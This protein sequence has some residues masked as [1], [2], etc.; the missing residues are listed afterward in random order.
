MK[1]I[2]LIFIIAVIT[3]FAVTCPEEIID[4]TTW[5][6][7]ES[8]SEVLLDCATG[9]DGEQSRFC[10][11]NGHWETIISNCTQIIC[12]SDM[13]EYEYVWP[14]T[15]AYTQN[16]QDCKTGYMGEVK[17][18]CNETGFW[19]PTEVDC[20][21]AC[22]NEILG[23]IEWPMTKEK[24]TVTN[25]CGEGTIGGPLT[26]NCEEGGIWGT[27]SDIDDEQREWPS[28]SIDSETTL[29]CNADEF[30]VYTRYCNH[31]GTWGLIVSTCKPAI[32]ESVT[33]ENQLIWP[34]TPINQDATLTCG[35]EM[36]GSISRS[37]LADG[38]WST[39]INTCVPTVCQPETDDQEHTWPKTPINEI[40]TLTCPT[41][42]IGSIT[43]QCKDNGEWDIINNSCTLAIC[44]S[45]TDENQ[46][47]WP[48]TPIN[49]DATLSCGEEMT[50]SIIRSCLSNAT[51]ST[52]I[53]TCVPTVC[54]PETDDQGRTWPKTPINTPYILECGEDQIGSIS[55]ICK[56]NGEWGVIES[57]CRPSVCPKNT[58]NEIEWPKTSIETTSTLPC[59][60]GYSG[61][62]S[63]YCKT[64]GEWDIPNINTC[65]RNVCYDDQHQGLTWPATDSL[66]IASITCPETYTGVTTRQCTASGV[67]E[68]A[69]MSGCI[70]NKCPE[71]TTI[72]LWE[73][74]EADQ[75][76]TKTCVVG[77]GSMNRYC[78]KGGIW[79]DIESHCEL[80]SCSSV[81]DEDGNIWPDTPVY[82]VAHVNCPIGYEGILNR[83]CN[84]EGQTQYWEPIQ[85]GCTII[86]CNSIEEDGYLWPQTNYA[87]EASVPCIAGYTGSLTRICLSTGNFSDITNNCERITCSP[88]TDNYGTWNITNSGEYATQQC[89]EYYH[90]QYKRLCSLEG[91]WK[92][93]I[94]ECE[95][96]KCPEETYNGVLYPSIPVMTNI[97]T[98][99]RLGYTGITERICNDDMTWEEPELDCVRNVCPFTCDGILCFSETYESEVV[100]IPCT[101]GSGGV[102]KRTCNVD[103][104]WGDIID[105]CT[106]LPCT[107]PVDMIKDEQNNCL[108]I[109]YQ[110]PSNLASISIYPQLSTISTP[111]LTT[112][113]STYICGFEPLTSYSLNIQFCD[114]NED[115]YQCNSDLS[116][117]YKNIYTIK[118]CVKPQIPI[119]REVLKDGNDY[120]VNMAVEIDRCSDMDPKGFEFLYTC[121]SDNCESKEEKTIRFLCNGNTI[122]C[123]IGT[124]NKVAF[125]LS[126]I[127]NEQYSISVRLFGVLNSIS[128]YGQYSDSIQVTTNT[129][130]IPES[131][132]SLHIETTSLSSVTLYWN[133]NDYSNN[134][135]IRNFIIDLYKYTT[136]TTT[137]RRLQEDNTMNEEKVLVESINVCNNEELCSVRS[138]QFN[139][140]DINTDYTFEIHSISSPTYNYN[141]DITSLTVH[142]ITSPS[143]TL[144]VI[145]SDWFSTLQITTNMNMDGTCSI[146]KENN[147][148]N[149]L[150]EVSNI[151]S[152]PSL[153]TIESLFPSQSYNVYCIYKY[154]EGVVSSS[155]SFTTLPF[156]ETVL[157]P[158]VY[159]I[160]KETVDLLIE[161]DKPGYVYCTSTTLSASV[162]SVYFIKQQTSI[163]IQNIQDHYYIQLP[164]SNTRY[165]IYCY[166][167]DKRGI[168][169]SN[170]ISSTKLTV[171]GNNVSYVPKIIS[172]FPMNNA[173]DVSAETI[174]T[175]TFERDLVKLDENDINNFANYFI[176]T[177]INNVADSSYIY[178]KNV[179]IKENIVY[180]T[181][182]ILKS[183]TTYSIQYSSST[184]LFDKYTNSPLSLPSPIYYFTTATFATL[185]GTFIT[186]TIGS[187]VSIDTPLKVT[188]NT[189]V[190]LSDGTIEIY[191]RNDP[192]HKI[193]LSTESNCVYLEQTPSLSTLTVDYMDCYGALLMNKDYIALISYGVVRNQQGLKNEP[194]TASFITDKMGI[195]A[196]IISMFPTE[197]DEEV[198]I[199][200]DISLSFNQP[201]IASTG[202]ILLEEYEPSTHVLKRKFNVQAKEAIINN[203]YP[204]TM[205]FPSST[206]ILN[207]SM[208]YKFYWSDNLVN[209][210]SDPS[211]TNTKLDASKSVTFWTAKYAC[212]SQSLANHMSSLCT[213]KSVNKAC[214]CSCGDVYAQYSP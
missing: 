140:M 147:I 6:E 33:D 186:P 195:A 178:M 28:I 182:P 185:E 76:I 63:R 113:N 109:Q 157:K 94:D 124:I 29:P 159:A 50:G 65:I 118:G 13:D 68:N 108:T 177:P 98:E 54:Q 133:S 58:Y 21:I 87:E 174:Y 80:G 27:V 77:T 183:A 48:Q 139:N 167:E 212:S 7:T 101:D 141:S 23:G 67:W 153:Y 56:D 171:Q 143:I 148:Q 102:Y 59:M 38:T 114:G 95:I 144:H 81:T 137:T 179:Q 41:N 62:M 149:Q 1:N 37:C 154:T 79:E 130:T 203:N 90:G 120:K 106:V 107:I 191:P 170:S 91:E 45:V 196:K 115:N 162:P 146:S 152:I 8:S 64:T 214:V 10:D 131:P 88:I 194:L 200:I 39:V 121:I 2:I 61:T 208:Q 40:A 119:V 18:F 72:T 20:T 187:I 192:S 129:V 168:A 82:E 53:N 4:E 47:V 42:Y 161:N 132:S 96:N 73:E 51:W 151:D 202:Y 150:I 160:N 155:L 11:E 145:P 164:D 135:A 97:T 126:T 122:K 198:P 112:K 49:Q 175:I 206:F 205:T 209:T 207:P 176:L 180:I 169:M 34:Q 66:E 70:K 128:Y 35:E 55:R 138:V 127:M 89:S 197:G 78:N 210:L 84:I 105:Q 211:L 5:P 158:T 17:R 213:C 31:D 30:G 156:K 116:C 32:C 44:E 57:T 92:D 110:Q 204:Y 15:N 83:T 189:Y 166:F 86:Q 36:T 99:C 52:V 46:L 14:E 75:T 165:N 74:T 104:S 201:I 43:R 163:Y 172:V 12:E 181:L 26:R 188:F 190:S 100:T 19:E 199:D 136:T 22:P 25:N 193:V 24:E 103:G 9:F 71:D 16:V 173:K 123:D 69:N 125:T 85:N 134:A 117:S 184:V 142:T 93:I 60:T 3:V 111:L